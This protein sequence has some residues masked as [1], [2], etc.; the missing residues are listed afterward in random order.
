MQDALQKVNLN[1]SQL[2]EIQLITIKYSY[3]SS[4]SAQQSAK[5]PVKLSATRFIGTS[6]EQVETSRNKEN[7][8]KTRKIK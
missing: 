6:H 8:V 7:Q 2:K 3:Y 4:V 1:I 5:L